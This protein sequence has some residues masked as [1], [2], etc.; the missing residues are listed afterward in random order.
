[1]EKA[2]IYQPIAG[3]PVTGGFGVF[4]NTSDTTLH[5]KVKSAA[6]FKTL[7]LHAT[8]EKDGR[9]AMVKVEELTIPPR[10]SLELK[11]GSYHIMLFDPTRELKTGETLPVVFLVNGHSEIY[12]FPVIERK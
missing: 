3:S 2:L 5:I 1:V 11:H 6:P 10:Q 12:G 4:K 7:E 8:L 9:M